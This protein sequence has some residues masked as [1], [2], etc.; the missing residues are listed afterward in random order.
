MKIVERTRNGILTNALGTVKMAISTSK[1]NVSNTVIMVTTSLKN[2]VL[3][4]AHRVRFYLME[5]VQSIS[6]S[7]RQ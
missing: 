4:D 6:K 3:K 1:E 7:T 2:N 5:I